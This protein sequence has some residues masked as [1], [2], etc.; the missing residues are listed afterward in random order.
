M[1]ETPFFATVV[2]KGK[3]I[4]GTD[5]PHD[6]SLIRKYF[7]GL[8][9]LRH[10]LAGGAR[11]ARSSIAGIRLGKKEKASIRGATSRRRHCQ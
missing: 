7:K 6:H 9:G 4:F 11:G 10:W 8:R 5:L 3:I 1:Q 2:E